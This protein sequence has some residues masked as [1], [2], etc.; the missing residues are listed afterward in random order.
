MKDNNQHKKNDIIDD[1]LEIIILLATEVLTVIVKLI[2]AFFKSFVLK[3]DNK[4]EKI[5]RSDLVSAKPPKKLDSLG[6]SVKKRK[7]IKYDELNSSKHTAIVGASGSGKSVLIN[8]LIDRDLKAG[9]PVIYLD[10]KG[11]RESMMTFINLC[12]VNGREYGVF[13][14]SYIGP[15]KVS[16]NPVK[17]GSE[18]NITDRLFKSFEWSDKYYADIAY[19]ALKEAVTQIHFEMRAVSLEAILEKLYFISDPKNKN[20]FYKRESIQGLI[21]KIENIVDSDFKDLI[22]SPD[23]MS[24]KELRDS[25]KC[26]YIGLS[27]LGYAETARSIGKLLLGDLNYSVFDVYRYINFDIKEDQAPLALFIDEL[28]AVITDEFIDLINKCRGAKVEITTAIQSVSDVNKVN[29]DLFQ[30]LFENSLNWFILK[31]RMSDGAMQ[32][33]N[34]IGTITSTKE[35]VRIE[36]GHEQAIGSQREVEELIVHPNIIKNLNVG[37]CILLRQQPTRID[38][39][40]LKYFDPAKLDQHVS[41]LEFSKAEN[42][43][44]ICNKGGLFE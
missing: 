33:S 34:A 23:G 22:A 9:K 8:T 24:F 36:G 6:Y 12:K 19:N 28:S 32:L 44:M 5:E 25:G 43:I 40:N 29:P 1:F 38:L 10:P 21:T 2:I 7:E 3:S 11:D 13:S 16:L 20:M 31:Q 27:V 35:T 42:K 4:I 18:T 26:I 14:E 17:E 15:N 30:Q 41:Q 39:L 37:Q